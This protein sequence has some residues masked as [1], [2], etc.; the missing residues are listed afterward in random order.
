ME[1]ISEH[2]SYQEAIR[3]ELAKR[4]KISNEPDEDH[5]KRMRLVA[6]KVF[7]PVRIFFNTRIYVSSFFRSKALNKALKGAAG[8]Q[9]TKGEAIDVDADVYGGVNNKQIF[10]YI[11]ANLQFDQLILEDVGPDG[12]GG[13]VHFSYKET[14]NRNEVLI[15]T[16]KDGKAVYANA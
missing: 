6:T 11:R 15:M 2:I 3:S 1:N 9:H 8:S 10:D 13:W 7:E 5:L 16:K 4:L 12:T 14:G